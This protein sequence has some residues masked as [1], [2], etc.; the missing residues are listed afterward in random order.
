MR[1]AARWNNIKLPDKIF[2]EVKPEH[3]DGTSLDTLPV[4][5]QP[6]NER[7]VPGASASDQISHLNNPEIVI[8]EVDLNYTF[9]DV[10]KSK[11]MCFYSVI[12]LIIW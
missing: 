2:T 1:R 9:V 11:R 6:M 10:V 12:L 4:Q 3:A 7:V 8:E 5:E